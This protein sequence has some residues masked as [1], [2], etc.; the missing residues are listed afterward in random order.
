MSG[1][2]GEG[3]RRRA[4][5]D[6]TAGAGLPG[7]PWAGPP[8]GPAASGAALVV[9]LTAALVA[10]GPAAAQDGDADRYRRSPL[11]GDDPFARLLTS[12]PSVAVTGR[13]GAANTALELDDVGAIVFLADR[14]RFRV[15]DALDGI[16]LVPWGE[17]L[18]G[19]GD[20][21]GSVRVAVPV[22]DSLVL[23]LGAGASSWASLRLDDDA[24]ALLRDGNA[25]RTEFGLGRTRG[26][27]LLAAEFGAH[28]AWRAGR[29]LGRDG[30]QLAFGGGLRWLRP[31]YYARSRSLLDDGGRIRVGPDS[32]RARVAVATAETPSLEPRGGGLLFDGLVRAEWPDRSFAL[33]ASVT[34]L[35]RV[36]MDG[37]LQRREEVDVATTRLDEVVDAVEDLS[38]RVRDTLSASVSPPADLHLTASS[39]ALDD[40][41]LDARLGVPFGGD[42][43]RPPPSVELLST[44][45][46]VRRL[47]L[48]A[49][50]RLGGHAETAYRLGTGWE[51]RRFFARLSATSAGG[52][53]GS[54]RGVSGDVSFG[55]WF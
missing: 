47:P 11:T 54:A 45:R 9:A 18:E 29:V 39:R 32:V 26:D 30:P 38:F 40:V 2:G 35:G 31:L 13:A 8:A 16:G 19:A 6:G 3:A 22:G 43:A 7:T 33:E 4:D 21:R 37:V 10:T 24:V 46:P 52:L 48:R 12:R 41:Q 53:F 28:A 20:G 17:G 51:G 5:P 36:G 44:W 1:R 27:V 49:G 42:F 14:D 25:D 55:V 15:T 23:G 50:L 34:G